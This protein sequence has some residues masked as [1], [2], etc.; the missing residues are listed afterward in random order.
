MEYRDKSKTGRKIFPMHV[1]DRQLLTK[2]HK[3]ICWRKKW[4][5][6]KRNMNMA[7]EHNK[8]FSKSLIQWQLK[9][10]PKWVT[11]LLR[12]GWLKVKRLI[13]KTLLRI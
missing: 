12:P 8:I 10:K 5:F 7:S 6:S 4:H 3:N 2:V 1:S 11:P 13:A 9:L